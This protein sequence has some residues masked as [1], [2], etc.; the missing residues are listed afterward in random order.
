MTNLNLTVFAFEGNTVRF[1]GT[2]QKPEWV[3][4]DVCSVLGIKNAR[5][6]LAD[7]E[8][9]EKGVAIVY[10]PGGSQEM[11]T[12]TEPGLY[13]LIFK[14]RKEI[15][16]RFQ[17]W[18]FHEVLPSIR[19]IG[20]YSLPQA[21][22]ELKQLE[23]QLIL[24]K[25]RYQDTGHAIALS[26]SP[27]MLRWLRGEAPPPAEVEY[28][29]RFIDSRSGKEVGSSRGRSLTQLITDAGLNPKSQRDRELVKRVL[30]RQGFD[31]D[32]RQRWSEASYLR[33][34]P[35][36][37][38]ELYDQV[39]KAVLGEVMA[40]ESE[41]NLFVHQMQQAALTPKKQSQTLQGVEQP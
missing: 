40:G 30:K 32:S 29:D 21:E 11:L 35:V 36:L 9:D 39:L 38:D 20:S 34:Y 13:R 23:L 10:T 22:A 31:Y 16:K 28:L 3:A 15:A 27:A 7:F 25:Q 17:R 26:T 6:T 41:Q 8:P 5:D 19:K 2:A 24:A 18:V 4:Q 12:V 37:T 33:K 1:V 14:S